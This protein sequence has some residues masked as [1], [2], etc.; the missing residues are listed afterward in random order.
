M[1]H[2][3][4]SRLK[5][6]ISHFLVYLFFSFASYGVKYVFGLRYNSPFR[7]YTEQFSMDSTKAFILKCP[8]REYGI[9]LVMVYD[10]IIKLSVLSVLWHIDPQGPN[11]GELQTNTPPPSATRARQ[12]HVHP[13]ARS[14][15]SLIPNALARNKGD[16]N[17]RGRGTVPDDP[18]VALSLTFA[19]PVVGQWF[20]LHVT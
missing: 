6:H 17:S 15:P 20:M 1:Y 18:V 7:K 10:M 13:G 8:F 4:T 5:Q 12:Y 2:R 19:A 16:R 3:K 9:I 14:R 11:L